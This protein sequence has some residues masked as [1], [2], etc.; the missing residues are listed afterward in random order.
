MKTIT[1]RVKVKGKDQKPAISKWWAAGIAATLT[2]M[3][4]LTINYRAFSELSEQ[5]V[6]NEGLDQRI[7]LVTEENLQIQEHIH[8]L[9][10]D[11]STVERESLKFGLRRPDQ[12]KVSVPTNK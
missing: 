8:Y 1:R 6:E 12:K 2:L 11:P 9:K 5:A 4:C 10:N 7:R 3:L